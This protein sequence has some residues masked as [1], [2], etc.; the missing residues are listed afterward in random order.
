MKKFTI[1]LL[2]GI[3]SVSFNSLSAQSTAKKP[4]SGLIEITP[5]IGYQFGGR[6]NFYEGEFKMDDNM[7]FGVDINFLVRQNQR[8][9]ISYSR[10][11]TQAHFRPYNTFIGDYNR[12]DGD[13]NINYILIGSHT[14]IPLSEKLRLFGGVSVGATILGVPQTNVS[15][16]WRFGLGVTGGVKIAVN[17]RIGIRLQGRLL[18]PMYF[19]GVGFYAGIGT[20]GASSGLSMNGGVIAFQGDFQGGLYFKLK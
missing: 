1:F 12:W 14:E 17:D 19:A 3:L 8:F 20:G 15:D 13:V 9:E 7:N 5:L 6:V 11:S 4:G 18:M 16:V 10:M 2:I